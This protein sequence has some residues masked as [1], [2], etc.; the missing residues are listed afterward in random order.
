MTSSS[1]HGRW[2]ARLRRHR[3]PVGWWLPAIP[4]VLAA[5]TVLVL[6]HEGGHL[7][8]RPPHRHAGHRVLRR[9]RARRL[10]LAHPLGPARRPQGHPRRRLREGRRHDRPGEGRPRPRGPRRSAPPAGRAASP[11]WPPGPVANLAF[12]L[13]LLVAAA[14]RRPLRR[15][16][17]PDRSAPSGRLGR[18]PRSVTT[19]TL[20]GMG[21]LVTDLDGYA[22]TMGDP[23]RPGRRGTD[24]LP[25]PRRRRPDLRRRRRHAG[26]GASCASSAS[27]RS[28]SAS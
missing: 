8:R 16:R 23:G 7:L 19:G 15:A 26:R 18:A 13:L 17:A 5:L 1:G 27:S 14:D 3:R 21:E 20:E 6:L 24:P 28:A 25:L 11:S 4:L 9:L 2:P 10:G 22:D 12:G